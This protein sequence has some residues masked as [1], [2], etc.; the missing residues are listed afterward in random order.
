MSDL[1]SSIS[2]S[3]T[4][5]P[6]TFG[7]DPNLFDSSLWPKSI[8]EGVPNSSTSTS[9]SSRMN[10]DGSVTTTTKSTAPD[11]TVTTTTKT[12][13]PDKELPEISTST[14][15]NGDTSGKTD[16]K[17]FDFSQ[18]HID[19]TED[20][21]VGLESNS[22]LESGSMSHP[23]ISSE[24]DLTG[25]E[26]QLS[27]ALKKLQEAEHEKDTATA[28]LIGFAILT[29]VLLVFSLLSFFCIRKRVRLGSK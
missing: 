25:L 28:G 2:G 27:D 24:S 6:R 23:G 19:D 14:T 18:L 13:H 5:Y 11:G 9:M 15:K 12:L 10:P 7:F 3:N 4:L 21:S 8:F 29:G 17:P 16:L 1:E 26:T 20:Y 22:N